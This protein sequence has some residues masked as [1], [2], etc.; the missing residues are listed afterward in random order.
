MHLGARQESDE[1]CGFGLR[2]SS[3]LPEVL[4]SSTELRAAESDDGVGTAN[5]PVH[6]GALEASSNGNFASRLDHAGRSAEALGV[7]LG[8]AH[9]LSVGTEILETAASVFG[10]RNLAAKCP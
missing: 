5:R 9:T 7:E 2:I 8:V 1:S 4:E 3:A 10:A 6:A